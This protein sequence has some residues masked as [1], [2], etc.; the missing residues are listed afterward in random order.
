LANLNEE[1]H[2]Q[3]VGYYAELEELKLE[4]WRTPTTLEEIRELQ[5]SLA[6]SLAENAQ[7]IA[8]NDPL[9]PANL[10]APIIQLAV[11]VLFLTMLW[12]SILLL[13]GCIAYIE[14]ISLQLLGFETIHA[15][16]PDFWS[17]WGIVVPAVCYLLCYQSV[18]LPLWGGWIFA[19]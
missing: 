2:R 7:A 10:P 5:E 12:D 3:S 11:F 17:H 9:D 15:L 4:N 1:L 16:G 19:C 6:E 14:E 8:A 13:T 18:Y